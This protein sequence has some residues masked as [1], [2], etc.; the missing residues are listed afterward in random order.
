MPPPARPRMTAEELRRH[1]G[2]NDD[3]FGCVSA[4]VVVEGQEEVK[5]SSF[6]IAEFDR[7]LDRRFAAQTALISKAIDANYALVRTE[8][9]ALRTEHESFRSELEAL[10]LQLA[11]F[12]PLKV[13][14]AEL[15]AKMSKYEG[16]NGASGATTP[17]T[18]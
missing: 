18:E 15:E 6:V 12:E 10:K 2:Y 11:T 7:G 13:K 1:P 14:I 4:L 9:V 8:V 17:K 3:D 5:R 16:T